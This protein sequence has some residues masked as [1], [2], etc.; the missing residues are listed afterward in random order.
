MRSLFWWVWEYYSLDL[1]T[2]SV[3]S[4]RTH[5]VFSPLICSKVL[6]FSINQT[7]TWTCSSVAYA[8]NFHGRVLVQGHMVV[9]CIYCALF[10][11]SQIDV[12]SMFPNQRF[13]E[14]CWR[15][16]AYFSTRTPLISC[17]IALKTNHQRSKLDYRRKINSTPQ[18]SSS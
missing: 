1:C 4:C 13:G 9:I 18:H 2:S 10:V 7:R 14:V 3:L 8:E 17:V 15:N 12:M 16:N 6:H 5:A 11:T